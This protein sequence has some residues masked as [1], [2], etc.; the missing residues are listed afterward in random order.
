MKAKHYA[1][2]VGQLLAGGTAITAA[3]Y[4]TYAVTTW[5]R[6]GRTRGVARLT[7]SGGARPCTAAILFCCCRDPARSATC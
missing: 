6:Y 3:S 1:G 5:Y 2:L 4:T 7:H